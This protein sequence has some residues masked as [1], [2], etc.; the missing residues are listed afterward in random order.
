M[1]DYKKSLP[2]LKYKVS[3]AE[4][5]EQRK[6]NNSSLRRKRQ[7]PQLRRSRSE[8]RARARHGEARAPGSALHSGHPHFL[9]EYTGEASSLVQINEQKR[10]GTHLP[11][12]PRT[13]WGT[14][15][16]DCDAVGQ[17]LPWGQEWTLPARAPRMGQKLQCVPGRSLVPTV[18]RAART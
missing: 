14:V 2:H 12:P 13:R 7:P 9:E 16:A 6:R 1:T 5:T 8:A 3:R 10:D 15:T 17:E 4:K 11:C 18:Q